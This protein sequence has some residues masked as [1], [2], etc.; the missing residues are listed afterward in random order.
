MVFYGTFAERRKQMSCLELAI[1]KPR[2]I[3]SIMFLH[4]LG[5]S[6]LASPASAVFFGNPSILTYT[7]AEIRTYAQNL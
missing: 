1:G 4:L 3:I 5:P 7:V 6:L 2:W